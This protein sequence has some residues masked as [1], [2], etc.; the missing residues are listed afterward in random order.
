MCHTELARGSNGHSYTNVRRGVIPNS[1]K[2]EGT[3]GPIDRGGDKQNV[4]RADCEMLFR[5]GKEGDSDLCY[6]TD[7]P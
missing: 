3:H 7:E 6:D 4:A 1:L 2:A 5:L